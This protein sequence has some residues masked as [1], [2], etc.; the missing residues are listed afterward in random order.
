MTVEQLKA[1]AYDE[2]VM[3]EQSKNNIKLINAEIANKQRVAQAE[4][5]KKKAEK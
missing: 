2:M 4:P 5:A 1:L 3:L